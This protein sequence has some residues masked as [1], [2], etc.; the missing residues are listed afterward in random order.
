MSA[1]V[2]LYT[3]DYCPYCERAKALLTKRAVAFEEV[4][5]PDD[6]DAQWDALYLRSKMKTMP[7]IFNG[8]QLIGGYTELAALD[9]RDQLQSLKS[10]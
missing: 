7:Q 8:E 9:S 6:D 10:S 5:V 4:R 2:K 1:K 3:M